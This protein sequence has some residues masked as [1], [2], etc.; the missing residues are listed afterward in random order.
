MCAAH[1]HT[2]THALRCLQ[3][4]PIGVRS[5]YDE[6]KRVAETLFLDYYRQH[7]VAI[8]IA[9]VRA[10]CHLLSLAVCILALVQCLLACSM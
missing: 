2:H 3:V 9:R 7:N 1:T 4:N 5:C 10:V 8:R 6:G